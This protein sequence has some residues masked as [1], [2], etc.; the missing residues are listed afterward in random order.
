[1]KGCCLWRRCSTSANSVGSVN[2]YRVELVEMGRAEV[3][4]PEL[5][6]M[7]D[8]AKWYEL[9]FQVVLVRGADRVLLVNTGP[10]RDLEAMNRG[11]AAFLG[12]RGAMRRPPGE[13]VLD[14][15]DA[16]GVN[17]SSVTDIVLTPLQLYTV[18]NVAAFPH[19]RLWI[20]RRGWEHFH[21][22]H[23]HPHD[24]RATSLPPE[25]LGY[26]VDDAWP[27]VRLLADEDE[28]APGVRTWWSG[29]HHRASVCVEVETVIG[30][31]AISDTFFFLENVE[32]N[33]P[34]GISENIYECL[35]AHAR[36]RRPGV[37]VVPLY[38]PKNFERF[39]GGVVAG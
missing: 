2:V 29:G 12:E 34:I 4:G 6:W 11:W 33:H 39:P 26:L 8:F 30:I 9:A 15:L 1:M 22:T 27:R 21:A 14:A 35:E 23:Q 19:A 16:R 10:A 38:D 24:D 17:A 36:V 31:V 28:V 25:I 5:F 3:P 7:R 13:F 18:S 37:T 20:S 32:R